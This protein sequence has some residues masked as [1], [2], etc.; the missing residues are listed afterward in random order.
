[1]QSHLFALRGKFG[2]SADASLDVVVALS[3]AAEVDGVRVH[4]D[5]H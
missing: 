5:V 1:M 4:V 3:V 2:I